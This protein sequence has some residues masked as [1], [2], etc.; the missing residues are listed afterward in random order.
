LNRKYWITSTNDFKRVRLSGKSYAH[1][2]VVIICAE[3]SAEN[4]RVGVITGKSIGN[5]VRRNKA[6][7]R[8]RMI[9]SELIPNLVSRVDLVAIGRPAMDRASYAE[10]KMAVRTL[11]ERARVIGKND[12]I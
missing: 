11:L 5:A 9:F 7:R 6:R 12:S 3:G 4:S 10:I 2:L 8:L 1:P